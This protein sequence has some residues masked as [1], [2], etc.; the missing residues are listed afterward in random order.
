M[1]IEDVETSAS[2]SECCCVAVLRSKAFLDYVMRCEE[3][4]TGGRRV[5]V[6]RD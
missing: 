4:R 3:G 2:V 5:E 6:N 1:R